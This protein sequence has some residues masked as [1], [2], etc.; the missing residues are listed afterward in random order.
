M[1]DSKLNLDVMKHL[2][3]NPECASHVRR[4]RV[5]A[6]ALEAKHRVQKTMETNL[7]D[8]PLSRHEYLACLPF[9]FDE[10]VQMKAMTGLGDGAK[11]R[12]YVYNLN[13]NFG[14]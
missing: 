14:F 8:R 2:L 7:Q 3:E 1:T 11:V 4:M 9:V 6:N 13:C 12:S 5:E 10:S